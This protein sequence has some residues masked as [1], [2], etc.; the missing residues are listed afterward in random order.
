MDAFTDF[1]ILADGLASLGDE[2]SHT[3]LAEFSPSILDGP[4]VA[5]SAPLTEAPCNHD[6]IADYGSYCVVA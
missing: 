1:S 6:Q 4:F 5:D 2:S 3:I